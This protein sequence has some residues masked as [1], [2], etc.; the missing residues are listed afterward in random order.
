M[1]EMFGRSEPRYRGPDDLAGP[2]EDL[3]DAP[4]DPDVIAGTDLDVPLS[5]VP[6]EPADG[7]GTWHLIDRTG[8]L[9]AATVFRQFASYPGGGMSTAEHGYGWRHPGPRAR[10]ARRPRSPMTGLTWLVVL[11]LFAAFFSWFSAEPL[12][13]SLGHGVSGTATV[14]NCSVHGIDG[15]CADFTPAGGAYPTTRVTLLG[16]GR[17]AAG[18]QVPARMVS[19]RGWQAYA[20]DRAGLY[21]RWVPGLLLVLLCGVGIALGTGAARLPGRGRALAVL[22]CIAGPILLA[23]GLFAAAW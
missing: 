16:L 11:G 1:T 15:R 13:L 6:L 20:G 8:R 21:L 17:V 2:A 3:A 18:R 7:S 19:A 14:V 10:V 23:A 9:E 4:T 22:A 5:P 12:W